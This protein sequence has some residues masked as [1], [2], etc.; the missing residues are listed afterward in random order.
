MMQHLRVRLSGLLIAEGGRED[1]LGILSRFER[2]LVDARGQHVE[3]IFVEYRGE[4]LEDGLGGDFGVL[5]ALAQCCGE[6]VVGLQ[7]E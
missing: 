5:G 1:D 6:C 7:L 4:E 3:E 2:Q